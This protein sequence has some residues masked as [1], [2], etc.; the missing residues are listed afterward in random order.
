MRDVVSRLAVVGLLAAM[1]ASA[2]PA[3]AFCAL[4]D[5]VRHINRM[6]GWPT[7]CRSLVAKI[8]EDVR[9]AVADLLPFTLHARALG[10]H[11]LYVLTADGAPKGYL[12]ARSEASPWGMVEV[13]WSFDEELRVRAFRFQRC[14]APNRSYFESQELADWLRGQSFSDLLSQL[15]LDGEG[16]TP[17]AKKFLGSHERLAVTVLRSALKAMAVTEIAWG[18]EIAERRLRAMLAKSVGATKFDTQSSEADAQVVIGRDEA[19]HEVG[20]AVRVPVNP[21]RRSAGHVFV[22]G[23]DRKVRMECVLERAVKPA[24]V[25]APSGESK[26]VSKDAA[27]R[28]ALQAA[29]GN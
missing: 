17:E 28:R 6:H 19:G 21:T 10:R 16:L 18:G 15:D 8:D 14:R 23:G 12:Q 11:T 2:V 22:F 13:V 4:R 26:P 9:R 3:Q 27:L 24:L 25:A 29:Y 20:R 7:K 5:P 1:A